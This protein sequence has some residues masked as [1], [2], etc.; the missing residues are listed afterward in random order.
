VRQIQPATP[1]RPLADRTGIVELS[2]VTRDGAHE[3]LTDHFLRIALPLQAPTARQPAAANLPAT[4]DPR[5][6]LSGGTPVAADRN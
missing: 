4:H 5:D 2:L 6:N 1:Y 3:P